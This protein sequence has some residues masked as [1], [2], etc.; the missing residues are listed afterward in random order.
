MTNRKLLVVLAIMLLLRS[1]QPLAASD[2]LEPG[3]DVFSGVRVIE[4]YEVAVRTALLSEHRKK[5]CLLVSLPSFQ[6]EWTVYLVREDDA[7]PLVVY[8]RLRKSLWNEM[9]SI[10]DSDKKT[11]YSE[12]I[13]KLSV[14]VDTVKT[15]VAPATADLLEKVWWEMLG[16]VHY[17]EAPRWGADGV[18]YHVMH[19]KAGV[20][21]RSGQTWSPEDGTRTAALINIAEEMR[22]LADVPN[23]DKE[24]HL[25]ASARTLLS[26][27]AK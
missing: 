3:D 6:R 15:T 7:N 18:I 16:R 4:P 9:D 10:S 20:G 13:K 8:K 26:R 21:T 5:T 2:D 14:P 19:W 17:P 23:K 11:T 24:L 27:L 22:S 25:Q 12:A 1:V